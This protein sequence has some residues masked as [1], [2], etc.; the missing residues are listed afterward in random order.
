MLRLLNKSIRNLNVSNTKSIIRNYSTSTTKT[1]SI[2]NS[3]DTFSRRHIGPNDNDI[4]YMLGKIATNKDETIKS[5]DHLIELTVPQNIRLNRNLLINTQEEK[6]NEDFEFGES[7]LLQQLKKTAEKNQIKRSFIGMGYYN[8]ITPYVIQ[9]NILEN[10]GWYTPYTPYQA[11]ISQGRLESLLN[12]QTMIADLTALP[13][14]NAS[15]LDEATAAAEAMQMCVNISKSKGRLRFLVDKHCHPQTIDTIKTRAEPKGIFIDV[16][17]SKDFDFS[18]GEVV[19]CIVQYPSTNGQIKDYRDLADRAHKAG[20]LVVC[21]TDLLALT[22]LT[23]PG[24]WGADIALGNSQR[25]GVPLG[26]G[27]PHAAFFATSYQYSRLLPGRIIGISKDRLGGQAYRMALQT[28]EQHIRREKATSNICTSQALLANMAAMYAVYHGPQGLKAIG[29]QVHKKAIILAEGVK[30]LGFDLVDKSFF[31]T[32]LVVTGD[33]TTKVMKELEN[34]GVNV[35]QYCSKSIAISTD[36]SM[37]KQDV[38]LIL[39]AFA[40]HSS[41]AYNFTL[42]SLEKDLEGKFLNTTI[43]KELQRTTE[44]LTHPVFNKYHSEHE[45]LRYIHRLQK[46]DLGLTTAM[47]PLGSCTMK[48]NATAEMY[49][50]SWPEF[51]QIHP[52][53]PSSQTQGY[54][55]MFDFISKSLCEVTGFD[56]CSL[57]PNAGSQ[58]EYTGLMV[59]REYLKSI[60]QSQRDICLIPVSAHGTN[61]ASAAM[62]GMKV[63]V[64]AC[65]QNGNVDKA[66]L[67]LKAEKYKDTLA[68]LMI[69]YP[70]THGVFEEGANEMCDIIHQYG[71][72]VYM[73]GA[74]MN[75]QVGLCRPGD[76]GADVCHLNLHKTFCIPHGGGGPGMGP[77]C[78]KSHLGPFLPG[79]AVVQEVGGAKAMGAVSAAPWGS[80]SILP[81]TYVYLRLMGGKGLKKA[82][83]VAI[84]NANYMAQRLKDHYKI[85]YTG[86]NGFV[87]HEFIIDLRHFKESIGIEAEDVAKRLQDYG[88]H[89]PT[90]SWPVPNTLMI[91]PTESESLYEL[92]RLCDALISI[93]Q[94]IQEIQDGKADKLDNVLV[95]APH[96]E[97]EVISDKWSHPYSREKAAFPSQSTKESK[98]WP[99]VAR[100]DNVFGDRN[101]VCSCNTPVFPDQSNS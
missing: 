67:K 52:F 32:I 47:I 54:K 66:D 30:N 15:L 59:I 24:E 19:G 45:L 4:K 92:N 44:F 98:F 5:L 2:F 79:H 25:F 3:L 81:I 8:S 29:Q 88:F 34:K 17:S 22:M 77:I 76:I 6:V 41:K 74:N 62:V 46:K 16:L 73:D 35:R 23:P 42:D 93:R 60:G 70:S 49:P 86:S 9:R 87:A 80:S 38:Q 39:D 10:P 31:D 68:A 53:A 12:F 100:V 28:R 51:G 1:S 27:G 99:T 14:A 55:E 21:A 13:M 63:V 83:Q 78:V 40:E 91:E 64:V 7:Q 85:L 90:M 18:S 37:T 33:K 56:N 94:E 65:D 48:L 82:T 57:Q 61:P 36:E 95:N 97:K 75:A 71:G 89:G 84:L 72:Q 69:T 11:E 20:S 50:V 58:G 26:F 96:I 101:L 43:P